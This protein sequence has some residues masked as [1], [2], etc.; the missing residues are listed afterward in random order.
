MAQSNPEMMDSLQEVQFRRSDPKAQSDGFC[1]LDEDHDCSHNVAD[2]LCEVHFSN[3]RLLDM[4]PHLTQI[5][6]PI[7]VYLLCGEIAARY[8]ALLSSFANSYVNIPEK[9]EDCNK[10]RRNNTYASRGFSI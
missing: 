10:C 8:F 3:L 5:F 7:A 6:S 4:S 1:S 2:R 9:R